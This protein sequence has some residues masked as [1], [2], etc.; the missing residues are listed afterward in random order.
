MS[1]LTAAGLARNR[2]MVRM[3]LRDLFRASISLVEARSVSTLAFNALLTG[4]SSS[5]SSPASS[6]SSS[7][8]SSC[9]LSCSP[10]S[11][12]PSPSAS[13]SSP[14]FPLFFLSCFLPFLLPPFLSF[15]SSH[16]LHCLLP[17]PSARR[18]PRCPFCP[19]FPLPP[20]LTWFANASSFADF[21]SSHL[22]CLCH[23][24]ISVD[25]VSGSSCLSCSQRS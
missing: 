10:V 20:A 7:F 22:I 9:L 3:Y 8:V 5:G 12:A 6:L 4:D 19:S 13:S 18:L 24:L 14:S 16:P 15:F 2:L 23:Y 1:P 11:S 25:F 21:L 17:C